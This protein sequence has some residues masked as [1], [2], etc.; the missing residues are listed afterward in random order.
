MW[1]NIDKD[2]SRLLAN[3]SK[4]IRTQNGQKMQNMFS[5]VFT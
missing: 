4:L 5:Y 1:V 2:D 3:A